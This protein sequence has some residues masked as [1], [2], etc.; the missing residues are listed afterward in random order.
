MNVNNLLTELKL[1]DIELTIRE[2]ELSINAPKGAI[3]AELR[4]QI[5]THKRHII[6]LL[7]GLK[8]NL[9]QLKKVSRAG[10]LPISDAQRGL[11]FL[12]QLQDG[13]DT[14]Y[15]IPWAY[16]LEGHL[17]ISALEKT[18]NTII[19]RHEALR[20]TFHVID[21]NPV[22]II[23]DRL[24][25][26]IQPT[27]VKE[28]Q[29][30]SY[31]NKHATHIFDL[32]QGPLIKIDLLRLSPKEHVLLINMHHIISDGWSDG[33]L[34]RE[35]EILYGAY[36][37]GETSLL[38]PLTIQY[39]D[40]SA[41]QSQ[42]LH[43][44]FLEKKI[45]YWRDQL[46]DAPQ[47]LALPTDRP[48][49]AR[50]N[51]NGDFVRFLIPKPLTKQLNTLARQEN[52]T[53]FVILM[54][55]FQILLHRYSG[56]TDIC[57]G[58]PF[59]NRQHEQLTG[60]IGFILNM[61]VLRGKINSGSSFKDY[62][63]QTNE[64]ILEAQDHQDIPLERLI[65]A[66]KPDR[67]TSYTPLFQVILALQTASNRKLKLPHLKTSAME[68]HT[69]T[70]KYDLTMDLTESSEGISGKLEY[71]TELF[72]QTTMERLCNHYQALLQGIVT[73][74]DQIISRLPCLNE[75]EKAQILI[76]WNKTE[77]PYPQDQCIHQLFEA[78]V[79]KAPKVT[80]V[81]YKD[82]QLTYE[83]LN[84]RSNQLAHYLIEQG[85]KPDS[86]VG[87]CMERSL[88]M[89]IG[90]LGILKAGGAYVPIDTEYP[91][92][93]IEVLLNDSGVS[94][95]LTQEELSKT[96]LGKQNIPLLCLD[97]NWA[98]VNQYGTETP[99]VSLSTTNLAYV[100]YTSGST[101]KPKGVSVPHRAVNR[102]VFNCKY[103]DF[104]AERTILQ[105]APIS[106]DAAT[107]EI[108]A[109]LLHGGKCILYGE[110]V[111][112][113]EMLKDVI[114][115][116]HIDTLWLTTAL[117][118]LIVDER[119]EILS[120][121]KYVLTGGDA[122]STYHI[123]RAYESCSNTQFI[124]M[125]GPTENT[126]FTSY[127]RISN[128]PDTSS[129]IPI[130]GP[131]GNTSIYILDSE[132]N[133]VPVG[134]AGE[135][136]TGGDGLAR[137]YLDRPALSAEN[138]IPN[139]FSERH[140]ERL[141]RT[142]D[143]ACYLPDGNIHFLGRIDN[144]VKIRGFRIELGEI[145]NALKE[146]SGVRE[147][148]VLAHSREQYGNQYLAAYIVCNQ[149][150]DIDQSDLREGLKA[151]LPDYMIPSFFVFLDQLPIT[152]NGKVNRKTLPIPDAGALQ[153]EEYVAPT[154]T[155]EQ[156][157]T[158][159]WADV[160]RIKA[161]HIGVHSNFF[162]LGG[163]SILSL[164]IIARIRVL[165]LQ[166]TPKQLFEHQ[167]IAELARVAKQTIVTIDAD[168]DQVTGE[169]PLLP[170]Q[171]RFFENTNKDLH[172]FN[173][174]FLFKVPET[175]NADVLS[176]AL[177]TLT[178]HHDVL[179]L[180]FKKTNTGWSQTLGEWKNLA[181]LSQIDLSSLT[182]ES[183]KTRLETE[184]TRI[185]ARL[186]IKQ[187]PLLRAA[188]FTLGKSRGNRLLI[189]IHHLAVDGVSWRI[190][191]EDLEITYHQLDAGESPK[192][193]P[194]TTSYKNWSTQLQ[195]YS[196][197]DRLIDE[198]DYWKRFSEYQPA[199]LPQDYPVKNGT[200]TIKSQAVYTV[201]L[202]AE[203]TQ[204]LLQEVPGAYNT[205]INDVLLTALVM[206]FY[207]WTGEERLFIDLEGHGREDLFDTVDLSRTVGW[208]TSI[209]PVRLTLESP[210]DLGTSLKA[211]KE[212][213]RQI[214]NR[215]MG[216]GLLRYRSKRSDISKTLM[217]QPA[218]QVVFNYLGQ[219]DQMVDTDGF[220]Q[221][222]PESV[223]RSQSLRQT[224]EHL[225]AINSSVK[226][227]CLQLPIAYN[228]AAH[229]ADTIKTLGSH[230]L[231]ALHALISHCAQPKN[232]GYTPSDFPDVELSQEQLDNLTDT[233]AE[234]L[235]KKRRIDT[236]Y[237]LSALQQG[238][239]Y[240]SQLAPSSGVYV[241]QLT[242]ELTGAL[243]R[244][245]FKTS[246]LSLIERHGIF[247]T[248]FVNLDTNQPLQIVLKQVALPWYEE[249]W[250]SLSTETQAER[251]QTLLVQDRQ[252]GFDAEQAPLMR[253]FV[254]RLSSERYQFIWSH[255][256][257]VLDGW[258]LPVII[259]ELFR[260]YQTASQGRS[261]S[262]PSVRPYREYIRWLTELESVQ[263]ENYWRRYLAGFSAPTPL[264]LDHRHDKGI[265]HFLIPQKCKLFIDKKTVGGLT[266][267][268]RQEKLTLNIVMQGVWALL[269]SR[270]SGENDVVFGKVVS[271][272]PPELID[273]ETMVGPFINTLPLRVKVDAHAELLPWLK[274]LHQSQIQQLSYQFSTLLDIQGWSEV[275]GG[276]N[277]FD[278]IF[279]F[280]N[281]PLDKTTE[282]LISNTGLN[283]EIFNAYEQTNYPL[284][285]IVGQN[286]GISVNI[287][288]DPML[289]ENSTIER[290]INH[291]QIL[292]SEMVL[293][294]RETLCNLPLLSEAERNQILIEWN[295]TEVTYFPQGQCIHHIF[296]TEVEKTPQTVAVVYEGQQLTYKELNNRSNQ[297]A[298]YLI[299]QNVRPD[300]RVGLCVE[301]SLEM[302]IGI[303]GILK[304]GG[305][306]V[307]IDPHYPKD[308][309][310]YMLKQA[311][312]TILLTQKALS[313]KLPECEQIINLDD[314]TEWVIDSEAAKENITTTIVPENL[315]YVI[316]TSGSTGRPKAVAMPHIA[317]TNLV[318]WQ[319]ENSACS[320]GSRTLQFSSFSFDV[321]FQELFSTWCS[322]GTL[323]LISEELRK[324]PFTLWNFIDKEEVN[325]IFM[326]FIAL[327]QLAE[328]YHAS[329]NQIIDGRT[330]PNALKEVITAGEQ[331][332]I[333]PL[334]REL[335]HNLE[336]CRL[337]N[338]YG[339]SETHVVTALELEGSPDSWESLP[340]VGKPVANNRIY[341]LDHSL[342]P[343]PIS[344]CGEIFIGGIGLARG[345]IGRDELTAERFIQNPFSNFPSDRLYRTG[346]L[347]RY[348]ID[349][350]IEFK[351][352]TDDQV[353]IRGFRI[354][355]SEIEN[356]LSEQ[357]EVQE[358]IVVALKRDQ[359]GHDKYLAA[360]LVPEEG[361]ELEQDQLR[362]SIQEILPDYM[363]PSVFIVL[364]ALPLTPSGK[365]DRKALPIPD[366]NSL[367]TQVYVASR[368]E[369]ESV[370]VSIWG[371]ILNLPVD[372][373]GIH[374]NFFDL[375]G[376]SL[377]ATR[378]LSQ[379]R[380]T[381]MVEVQIRDLFI[382]DTI[383]MLASTVEKAVTNKQI[384]E[385]LTRKD[386]SGNNLDTDEI[387]I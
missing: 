221:W 52:V 141:Y 382:D 264:M 148:V 68:S 272:R 377:L 107:F 345:Y 312:V 57:V 311:D 337:Y 13:K 151:V 4:E 97:K 78:Q 297:L 12:N 61:I 76:D 314:R 110:K 234:S 191:L 187:G 381:F 233:L 106:F 129:T 64:T 109:A 86:R 130:G 270:Y 232:Y 69:H 209:F 181:A 82:E 206:A 360:Y 46:A 73:N 318:Q 383:Q 215:G 349:G 374:D 33:V 338:H 199:P 319:L 334:I 71:N 132:L 146:Q 40:F 41:W 207:Q 24:K 96:I 246:W 102:L 336:G 195:E 204:T 214:P 17:D 101:G 284:T 213:L 208:F 157:L 158:T 320:V 28:V 188:L 42:C 145:E 333:T 133:P 254:I 328:A 210:S 211:I 303:L 271:G 238:M 287:T 160:L 23:A 273:V 94:L 37:K 256:H 196:Q 53:L 354:E 379:I 365:I 363:V 302:V 182:P 56:Q 81:V 279:V 313:K 322:G 252:K 237:P 373:I 317:L 348:R 300:S 216:Y 202:D 62:L 135:L 276:T 340:T 200:N 201:S 131:V 291:Y 308:R 92:Q 63:H 84:N 88:E 178:I 250:R 111:P 16:R 198:W 168:Q 269:L 255:H 307:P 67:N 66:L 261:L 32:T 224:Q 176:A 60:L 344:V 87:L 242:W 280:E 180:R 185:Q 362:K 174:A 347:A 44:E 324:D 332:Q 175:L 90:T 36:I 48:R 309:L 156:Q 282:E 227:G 171:Q 179:R 139:P 315:A 1:K 79:K 346:D 2:N 240:H 162:E 21:G 266:A 253:L 10:P 321:S 20:T 29:V 285:I 74:L 99:D 251:L 197:A 119:P 294:P 122:A 278:S 117:F 155:V 77:A 108:W 47:L 247:R 140:G 165:G 104:S 163:D 177:E 356:I 50:K 189:A 203:S 249:D 26:T 223:G 167:T 225:L 357:P 49:P 295:K 125:Y 75:Q 299:T 55:T 245:A 115:N 98:V 235:D 35:I 3:S 43:G 95:L 54:A 298:H 281:Y 243:N 265:G 262:L 372:K 154:T 205:Q 329:N 361:A 153:T 352:R 161:E 343:V 263:E 159:V 22:Q 25:I 335:F 229:N 368:T 219:F 236:L 241:T 124:N 364:E 290:L 38:P 371:D 91:K 326:P 186:N 341:I 137:G 172:H 231:E 65:E 301:R 144:Q 380:K 217:S 310:E 226:Y 134:I 384:I 228:Q 258:S 70:S 80:A 103:M 259:H 257:A 283:I 27:N 164:Q 11:W 248:L 45:N 173:Q 183:Q 143:L 330:I 152:P 100:I 39:A 5:T 212:Q 126:T 184:A 93:R 230:L 116:S 268:V 128:Q 376:H 149:R 375:G 316:Y 18:F 150:I 190:L 370:L 367:Q 369:V 353:K 366:T 34:N 6:D 222:A 293:H 58:S 267:L 239:L 14:Q 350:T 386:T 59:A 166:L 31:I 136:Y 127:Y 385:N 275:G 325:R 306:Y 8:K 118:N 342:Q 147:A 220:L 169:V 288:Y 305:A 112:T 378:V 244:K 170:I 192:L 113:P 30:P 277:L 19:Q 286:D 138:F 105:A 72:N 120:H 194:K 327:Q 89:V 85:V 51:Y 323:V 387:T 15:N 355:P 83:E 331:L 193:P 9:P 142:G 289:F 339:P 296:E 218:A 123:K 121:V 7:N 358:A 292:L 114:A 351:G 359:E 304:A 260:Y 274:Q